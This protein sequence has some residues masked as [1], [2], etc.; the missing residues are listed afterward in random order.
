MSKM[1]RVGFLI[2]PIAGMGGRVGLKGT[3]NVINEAIQRGAKPV[4]P[5]KAAEM[6]STFISNFSD[7]RVVYNGI[8]R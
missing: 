8:F 1:F 2:N 4:S 3:D 6:L 5:I 7:D